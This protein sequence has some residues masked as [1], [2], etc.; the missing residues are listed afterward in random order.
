M[1]ADMAM[2]T[3]TPKLQAFLDE[4]R[5]AFED[6]LSLANLMAL[7]GN[8]QKEFKEKLQASE[9]S[10]LP[11]FNHTLP[12]GTENGNYL[13]LDIGGTN[14]RI[15]LVQLSG[16]REDGQNGMRTVKMFSHC[17]SRPIKELKGRKF[18]AWMAEKIGEA[19]DDVEI[20]RIQQDQTLPM[21]VAWSFPIE[22]VVVLCTCMNLTRIGKQAYVQGVS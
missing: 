6:P 16:R 14:F 5:H 19:L 15:A 22:Y 18:F 7:S 2:G 3:I 20:T 11:S 10:M 4:A 17:I 1:T 13:A 8:L 12:T 21:G 9:I